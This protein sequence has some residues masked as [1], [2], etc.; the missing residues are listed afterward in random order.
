MF[1][2]EGSLLFH[3]KEAGPSRPTRPS[4]AS[5][6]IETKKSKCNID[7]VEMIDSLILSLK[8]S[9]PTTTPHHVQRR[10]TAIVPRTQTGVK[11]ALIQAALPDLAY[12]R[13]IISDVSQIEP[14]VRMIYGHA[15][16]HVIDDESGGVGVIVFHFHLLRHRYMLSQ[17]KNTTACSSC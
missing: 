13:H 9:S 8:K 10:K 14:S 3:I 15:F 16:L 17:A 7:F 2:Q 5:V 4:A 12:H 1:S 6:R 11:A